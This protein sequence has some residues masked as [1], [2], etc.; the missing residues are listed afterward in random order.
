MIVKGSALMV[1]SLGLGFM[2][3]NSGPRGGVE[4]STLRLPGL[5]FMP[6]VQALVSAL[7][8]KQHPFL[9]C[10]VFV[11]QIVFSSYSDMAFETFAF[12]RIS[13][14]WHQPRL[15]FKV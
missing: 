1:W 3:F 6:R 2:V 15:D 10:W 5:G 7:Q 13:F 14:L 11:I 12:C 8:R 4:G 9:K